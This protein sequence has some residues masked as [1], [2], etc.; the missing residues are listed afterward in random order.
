[1]RRFVSQSQANKCN[2]GSLLQHMEIFVKYLRESGNY[3]KS[4]HAF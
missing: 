1:M 4:A 3:H 2:N